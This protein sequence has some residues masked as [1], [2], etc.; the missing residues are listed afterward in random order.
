MGSKGRRPPRPD[1]PERG[2]LRRTGWLT[3]RPVTCRSGPSTASPASGTATWR[4]GPHDRNSIYHGLQAALESRFGRGSPGLARLHLV[5]ADCEH[6]RGQRRRPG[7]E[8]NNAYID[9]TN[10]ELERSRRAIDRTHVFTGSLVL[11]LPTLEDKS[12]FAQERLRR[13]GGHEHRPGVVGLPDHGLPR[14]RPRALRE[15]GCVGR[16]QQ[17]RPA[18]ERVAGQDCRAGGSVGDAM[19]EPGGLDASTGY[20]I[21][22]NG[23]RAATPATARV[24]SRWTLPSTRTSGRPEGETA[25][26]VRGVQP[27]QQRQLP[28]SAT[29]VPIDQDIRER[30]VRHRERGT[31]T[32]IISATPRGNFGQLIDSAD[33]RQAQFG[34]RLSF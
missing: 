12:A 24:S 16:G 7:L 11:V 15:R 2:R 18:A 9:S 3:L 26:P 33:N 6:R 19:A 22:T 20:Q 10:P 30:G 14:Q 23:N 5:Q 29:T 32:R 1:Q 34:I 8:R 4:S 25:A 13:L 21:G 31:A 28:A 27:L 17:R